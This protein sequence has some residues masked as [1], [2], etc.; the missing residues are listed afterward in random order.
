MITKLYHLKMFQ[1]K[2][3]DLVIQISKDKIVIVRI[4]LAISVS[5]IVRNDPPSINLFRQVIQNLSQD[6]EDVR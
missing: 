6:V 3:L 4:A 2:L 5:E 1:E